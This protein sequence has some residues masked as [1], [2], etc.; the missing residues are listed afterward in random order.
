MVEDAFFRVA[1]AGGGLITRA[2]N[3]YEKLRE[4]P[5]FIPTNR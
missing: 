5:R 1:R 4:F 2:V 3:S